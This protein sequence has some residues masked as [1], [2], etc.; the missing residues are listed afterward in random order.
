MKDANNRGNWIWGISE[1]SVISSQ[2]FCKYKTILDCN[3]YFKKMPVFSN[4]VG[5]EEILLPL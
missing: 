5:F 4:T 1:L 3:V 2:L